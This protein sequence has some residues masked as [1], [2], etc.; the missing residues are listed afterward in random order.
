M[1][2]KKY[3]ELEGILRQFSDEIQIPM[4]HLDI[5]LWYKETKEIFK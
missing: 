4:D 2:P 1:P 5:V 3:L